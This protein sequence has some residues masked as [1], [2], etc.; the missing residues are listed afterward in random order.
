MGNTIYPRHLVARTKQ[1]YNIS[2]DAKLL[3]PRRNRVF[4]V[5]SK[6]IRYSSVSSAFL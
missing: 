5:V 1:N 4:S 3:S 6:L 2:N